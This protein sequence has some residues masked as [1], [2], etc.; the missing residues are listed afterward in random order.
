MSKPVFA[1]PH[2]D[3]LVSGSTDSA[4]AIPVR[5]EWVTVGDPGNSPD[6]TVQSDG[7]RIY[8]SVPYEYHMGKYEVTNAQYAEFLDAVA[9]IVDNNEL[10]NTEMGSHRTG[11]IVQLG[12]EG[13]YSYSVKAGMENK[14]VNFVGFLDSLR[15]INWLEN[16]QPTGFQV[17]GTTEDG[18]YT[19]LRQGLNADRVTRNADAMFVLP[20]EDEWY[21]AAYY[22]PRMEA[23]GGPPGND[24]YWLYPTQSDSPPTSPVISPTGDTDTRCQHSQRRRTRVKCRRWHGNN[25]RRRGS[26]ECQSLRHI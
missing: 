1:T 15:F 13:D 7:T 21:K 14:P 9:S 23:E 16:G 8:G 22:D 10:Y 4:L 25:R 24:H 12:A 6:T 3:D 17:A 11:G 2:R 19:I 5:I 26:D 18:S 20:S